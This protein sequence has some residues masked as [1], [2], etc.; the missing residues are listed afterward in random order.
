MPNKMR[1]CRPSS[2]NMTEI[3]F[4]LFRLNSPAGYCFL[5]YGLHLYTLH[6]YVFICEAAT[7][8]N[9]YSRVIYRC[10]D[11]I[12]SRL[13][14]AN[15]HRNSRTGIC[16][17][18]HFYLSVRQS[19]DIGRMETAVIHPGSEPITDDIK[20]GHRRGGFALMMTM[21]MESYG[22]GAIMWR[23]ARWRSAIQGLHSGLDSCESAYHLSRHRSSRQSALH[24]VY[25]KPLSNIGQLTLILS[26]DGDGFFFAI[27]TISVRK[28]P[29]TRVSS[30]TNIWG[31]RCSRWHR[32]LPTHPSTDRYPLSPHQYAWVRSKIPCFRFK[33]RHQCT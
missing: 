23:P 4:Q 9:W 10:L 14:P 11:W 17:I 28:S 7:V 19:R 24:T 32:V 12:A 20:K 1:N 22:D 18:H 27:L 6:K 2:R 21:T 33:S 3:Y 29:Q 25:S 31:K 30:V 15:N 13:V 26:P 16:C 8:S 5:I